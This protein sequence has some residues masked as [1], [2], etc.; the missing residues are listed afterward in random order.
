LPVVSSYLKYALGVLGGLGVKI[1][2]M[3]AFP[4]WNYNVS[5]ILG[6]VAGTIFNYL[7]CQLWAFARK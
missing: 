2:V 7:A 1:A 6:I 4:S 5:N 3:K